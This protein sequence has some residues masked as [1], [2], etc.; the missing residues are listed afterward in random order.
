[1]KKIIVYFMFVL[2]LAFSVCA[3]TMT[4]V[5]DETTQYFN[6]DTQTFESSVAAWV[7]PLWTQ[8]VNIPGAT[9][10][11]RTFQVTQEE[12]LTGSQVL[13]KK[14]V[15]IPD[16]AE[17][18]QGVLDITTDNIY[19]VSIGNSV[20]GQDGNWQDVETYD[21]SQYLS[22]GTQ[23]LLFQTENEALS[24]GNPTSN[25]AGLIY[26]LTIDYDGCEQEDVPEFTTL[27]AIAVLL[28]AGAIMLFRR[29]K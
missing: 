5:S 29:K 26:K 16:C 22:T 11:W 6:E 1:M 3:T 13:F 15:E 18:I 8:Y 17:N 9:W 7:H 28:G 23:Y 10:I 20:V 21:V 19:D 2:T 14:S 4:V 12:A 27:G 24:N 25:P